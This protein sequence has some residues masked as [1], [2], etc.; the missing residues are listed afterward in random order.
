MSDHT[1][2]LAPSGATATEPEVAAVVVADPS[3]VT[4]LV[5]A[6]PPPEARHPAWAYLASLNEKTSRPT[7][8][9]ALNLIARLCGYSNLNVC[10]WQALRFEHVN[11]IRAK[12]VN[13]F[14]L[15]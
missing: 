6:T 14:V 10:P 7:M 3:L 5:L 9:H 15:S 11:A 12:L 4:D 8:E 1:K 13:G 2:E